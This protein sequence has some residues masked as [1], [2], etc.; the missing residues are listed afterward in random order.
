M[1]PGEI[2]GCIKGPA[3][4]L[5]CLRRAFHHRRQDVGQDQEFVRSK[6]LSFVGAGDGEE[7][8]NF[9]PESGWQDLGQVENF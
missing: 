5:L 9:R 2:K 3:V 4:E 1:F 7:V 8:S 6:S